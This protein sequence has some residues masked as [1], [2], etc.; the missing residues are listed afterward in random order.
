MVNAS[1][2]AAMGAAPER[3]LVALVAPMGFDVDGLYDGIT[4][5]C[6]ELTAAVVGGD[7]S[8]AAPGSDAVTVT[9]TAFGR[10][11][12]GNPVTR[13]GARPGDAV[14]VSGSL[15]AAAAGLRM[16]ARRRRDRR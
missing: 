8:A 2:L 10:C 1:D 14:W 7:L 5:A 6:E 11:P 9:V 4:E 12:S 16:L 3:L 15:G 13:D